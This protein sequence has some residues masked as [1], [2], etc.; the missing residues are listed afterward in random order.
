MPPK[1]RFPVIEQGRKHTQTASIIGR[2][3]LD[4]GTEVIPPSRYVF[5]EATRIR[6]LRGV[7]VTHTSQVPMALP[8]HGRDFSHDYHRLMDRR[9]Y[10]IDHVL[11]G[12]E[13]VTG[14]KITQ[15]VIS[16]RN[17]GDFGR[18]ELAFD[19]V[20]D[21]AVFSLRQ[22]TSRRELEVARPDTLVEKAAATILRAILF[23]RGE[24]DK[25][26]VRT[27]KNTNELCLALTALSPATKIERE[28][29]FNTAN[30]GNFNFSTL[31][32][33]EEAMHYAKTRPVVSSQE[34]SCKGLRTYAEYPGIVGT[35]GLSLTAGPS[36]VEV[37]AG[38]QA[39]IEIP[40]DQQVSIGERNQLLDETVRP[41]QT[42]NGFFELFDGQLGSI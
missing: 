9:L 25:D 29:T 2:R 13:D 4:F 21:H 32:I 23:Q 38:L 26:G 7:E 31:R 24:L 40:A 35:V 20:D 18:A 3:L 15:G 19:T 5:T 11:K 42:I 8:N 12:T 41:Y 14:T 6:V 22:A 27:Y 1:E 39:W 37:Q 30:A 33:S 17:E 28:R 16:M 10:Y 34:V 36:S